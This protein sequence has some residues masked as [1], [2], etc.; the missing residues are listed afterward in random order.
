MTLI[1]ECD[2]G[3]AGD[4]QRESGVLEVPLESAGSVTEHRWW[5]GAVTRPY[6]AIVAHGASR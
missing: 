6:V 2:I 3:I 1:D 4:A 5:G